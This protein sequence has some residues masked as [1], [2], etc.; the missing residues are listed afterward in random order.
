MTKKS[1]LAQVKERFTD[2]AGLIKAVESLA[3][4][5]LWLDRT[6]ADKGL[7]H[8]SNAKLLRLHATL[9][10]VQKEFGSRAGLITAILPAE[11]RT[12]DEGYKARLEAHPTPRLLDAQRAAAKRVKAASAPKRKAA[13]KPAAAAAKA[14]P[15]KATS[16]QKGAPAKASAAKKAPAKKPAKRG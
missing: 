4:G 3:T 15:A 16:A 9:S 2:K 12:K 1:P 5:D 6:N 13:A 14:A 8:V 11:K 7:A 10:T